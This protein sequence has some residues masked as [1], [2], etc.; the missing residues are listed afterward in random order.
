M[1]SAIPYLRSV[2]D[3]LDALGSYARTYRGKNWRVRTTYAASAC[4]DLKHPFAS[5]GKFFQTPRRL[6][7]SAKLR[8]LAEF[9]YG[10]YEST[11]APFKY[12]EKLRDPETIGACPYCG[13]SKNITVDHYLPR[14]LE[15]F[16]HLSFLSLNLVPACSD[17]QGSK[18][19]FYASKPAGVTPAKV[20]RRKR[21]QEL[22]DQKQGNIK[23]AR[24][25]NAPPPP[26]LR[27]RGP[28][29][30]RPGTP[31]RVQEV[32]RCIHPYLDRFL[33]RCVFDVDLAWVGGRPEIGRL[34]WRPHLTPSQR[35]LV[36]F[37][38][39]RMKVKERARG[40]VRRRYRAFEKVL[41][42]KGFGENEIVDRLEFR[43]AGVKKETGIANS[44]EAKCLEALLRD[45][46]AIANLVIASAVPRSQPL[47][48]VSTAVPQAVK[49]RRRYGSRHFIY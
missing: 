8:G 49:A 11:A 45:P 48:L 46:T 15:A 17:C 22:F 18:S 30:L 1:P 3:D 38:L 20:H 13:L 31:N 43:L 10:L 2:E 25:R 24:R 6:L 19:S 35:A 41:A 32:R 4:K 9:L 36:G 5:Y 23:A 34:L 27:R 42:G 40:I 16:P 14:K 29:P 28:T 39:S 37:H 21:R 26:S 33:T 44:I 12:I 47:T 7:P